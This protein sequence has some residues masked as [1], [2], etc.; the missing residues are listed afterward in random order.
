MKVGIVTIFDAYNYGS[1]LQAF[2][3]Q[4]FLEQNGHNVYMID[5]RTSLKSVVAQKYFAKS[6]KRTILKL[7]RFFAYRKDWKK[8]NIVPCSKYPEVDIALIGS[9]EVWNI[10]NGSFDHSTFY[11]GKIPRA[12]KV[13]AYA[14]SLGYSTFESYQR[15]M[16]LCKS[17]KKNITWFGAR[18]SFTES[19]LKAIGIVNI[20]RVCD[21]TILLYDKWV[22][23][24][25]MNTLLPKKR[26]M[27]Y[28]SYKE[29]TPFKDMILRFAAEKRL[30]VISVGFDYKW[31]DA[32][33]IASPFEFLHLV[34]NAS[35]I[36]TSTYHGTLFSTMYKKKFIEVEPARKVVD[37]LE[38]IGVDRI[39]DINAG[40]DTFK[41]LL[42][43]NIDYTQ[44]FEKFESMRKTSIVSLN[45][46]ISNG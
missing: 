11:Y 14:P 9:D 13:I 1:F 25:N 3:M 41:N 42:D 39:A 38:Q 20:N 28:Y 26:Y 43:S 32:Q 15:R 4:R 6:I 22:N 37:Y 2:A 46:E 30:K 35:Y 10:E 7:R 19:F 40:Y 18:D 44:I 27:I 34:N 36:V 17:I 45:L 29:E 16:D 31:C 5:V 24:E 8:L 12:Q 23:F 33:I 21:P